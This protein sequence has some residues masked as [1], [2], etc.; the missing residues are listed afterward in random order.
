[1][2]RAEITWFDGSWSTTK[3][4]LIGATDHAFWMASTVFDGARSIQG[5]VP[6]IAA[7]SERLIRSAVALGMHPKINREEVESLVC[8]GLKR[9]PQG[10][11]DYYIKMLFFCSDGF[12]LPDPASTALALHIFESPLPEDSGFSATFSQFRRPE[13]SMA[14]TDAKASCLY[15]N[16][17]RVL[18]DATARGFDGAVVLD[19]DGHVAE[20]AVANLWIVRDGVAMTPEL[21][22]AFLNGITRQ[23]VM[24]LLREDGI[25]VREVRLTP[26]D[27][28][29]AD[30]LF[31]TG[32]HG[33]VLHCDRIEDR[34]LPHGPVAS[35]ARELYMAYA[36]SC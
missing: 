1:M 2:N 15:P 18:R 11:F 36:L 6:D 30:E 35:R 33:K 23:R 24:A 32:N 25:E 12:L 29:E 34:S 26:T 4:P 5:H 19:P 21:N 7:H 17:Q 10:H 14:P 22:G 3:V 27:V 20:F 28:L 9:L 31:S 8:E 16:T 13:P